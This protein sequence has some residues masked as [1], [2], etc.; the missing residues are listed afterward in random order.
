MRSYSPSSYTDGTA[1][2][3]AARG[4]RAGAAMRGK[5]AHDRSLSRIAPSSLLHFY[6]LDCSTSTSHDPAE[7][8]QAA[9]VV[10]APKMRRN[11]ALMGEGGFEAWSSRRERWRGGGAGK[12]E[13]LSL[14]AALTRDDRDLGRMRK[15]DDLSAIPASTKLRDMAKKVALIDEE[16]KVRNATVK[17]YQDFS[18]R[19]SALASLPSSSS[20]SVTTPTSD[21]PELGQKDPPQCLAPPT[22]PNQRRQSSVSPRQR[23][24]RRKSR[25][26]P[27][28]EEDAEKGPLGSG[29]RGASRGVGHSATKTSSRGLFDFNQKT[30]QKVQ[31]DLEAIMGGLKVNKV[32]PIALMHSTGGRTAGGG[33]EEVEGDGRQGTGRGQAGEPGTM[34]Y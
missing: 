34:K 23:E 10:E 14:R 19:L 2:S 20:T 7:F 3:S 25:L 16:S 26:A 18:T 15:P 6:Y 27:V 5:T 17:T 28:P 33:H 12:G 32:D 4:G 1:S 24:G 30:H 11:A 29:G 21:G 8:S 13:S 31:D 22:W 9:P